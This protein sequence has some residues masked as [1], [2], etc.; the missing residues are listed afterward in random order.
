MIKLVEHS[1]G[2]TVRI[3]GDLNA[4]TALSLGDALGWAVQHHRLVV[5]DLREADGIDPA[6]VAVL[7]R[8]RQR[9]RLR[10]GLLYI[11][12]PVGLVEVFRRGQ[13]GRE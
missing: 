7:R 11:A 5:V 2:I 12:A 6:G 10:A 4:V 1:A 13:A 3:R 9:A 8:A